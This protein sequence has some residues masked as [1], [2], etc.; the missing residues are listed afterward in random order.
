MN[1]PFTMHVVKLK[2][3]FVFVNKNFLN[4]GSSVLTYILLQVPY[5][6]NMLLSSSGLELEGTGEQ[7][8][9]RMVK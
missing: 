3:I 9:G 5:F 6:Q 2:Q 1:Q 4:E 7:Q 8:Q